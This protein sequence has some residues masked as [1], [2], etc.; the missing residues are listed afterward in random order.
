MIIKDQLQSPQLAAG[1]Y[2]PEKETDWMNTKEFCYPA[3]K[4]IGCF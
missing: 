2:I 1:W 4:G 3:V